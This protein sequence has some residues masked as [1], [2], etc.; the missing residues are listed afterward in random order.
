MTLSD[1]IIR[2]LLYVGPLRGSSTN[3]ER[4]HSSE[5]GTKQLIAFFIWLSLISM[6]ILLLTLLLPN[7]NI[8]ALF[9]VLFVAFVVPMFVLYPVI[10][11][12]ILKVRFLE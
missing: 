5:K 8:F 4:V 9:F 6:N 10:I 2:S 7:L 3:F 1:R 11:T 12:K